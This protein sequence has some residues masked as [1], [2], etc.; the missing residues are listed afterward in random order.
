VAN[1]AVRE[2]SPGEYVVD[3]PGSPELV[4]TVAIW[5]RD[6]GVQLDELH[7]GRRTLE[8]VFLRLTGEE[9]P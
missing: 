8:E 6:R 7:T 5:M 4:A 2:R 1:E 3:V 9:A